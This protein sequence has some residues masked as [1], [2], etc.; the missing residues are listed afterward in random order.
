MRTNIELDD[1]LVAEAMKLTGLSTKKATVQKALEEF[2]RIRRQ[3]DALDFLRGTGWDGDLDEM[4]TDWT[5][6]VDWALDHD[7]DPKLPK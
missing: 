6:G 5:A 7:S 4:R 2:V 3:H 1:A